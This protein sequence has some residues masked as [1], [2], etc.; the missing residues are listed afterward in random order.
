MIFPLGKT[1]KPRKK[2]KIYNLSFFQN[3]KRLPKVLGDKNKRKA[4]ERRLFSFSAGLLLSFFPFFQPRFGCIPQ[5]SSVFSLPP[6]KSGG[7]FLDLSNRFVRPKHGKLL[8]FCT[9]RSAEIY[10][11]FRTVLPIFHRSADMIETVN[12]CAGT[13]ALRAGTVNNTKVKVGDFQHERYLRSQRDQ[14]A[15]KSASSPS[16]PR[17][18]S[19]DAGPSPG[20]SFR[21]YSVPQGRPAGA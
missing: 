13:E 6:D 21:R 1:A 12:P 19:S 17:A 15:E 4:A 7:F 9:T 14:A 16:R 2:P 20:A 11:F 8:I 10:N 18:S 5:Y 3:Y